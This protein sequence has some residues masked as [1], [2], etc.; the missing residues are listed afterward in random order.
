MTQLRFFDANAMVGRPARPSEE[1]LYEAK[2]LLREMDDL[3]IGNAVVYHAAARDHDPA[4]GNELLVQEVKG[5]PRLRPCYVLLPTATGEMGRLEGIERVL[6]K[7]DV[8][9]VRLFP[10]VHDYRPSPWLLEDLF[11]LLGTLRVP[12]ILEDDTVT[13]DELHSL[14]AS[15]PAVNILFAQRLFPSRYAYRLLEKFA[16]LSVGTWSVGMHRGVED[17]VRRFGPERLVFGTRLPEYAAGGY[18]MRVTHADIPDEAKQMI[19]ERNLLRLM[20]LDGA[21]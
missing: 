19:A 6:K 16:N 4:T 3:G 18:V 14:L 13:Q 10:G 11:G 21:R 8:R 5:L 1:S 12:V 2:D 9:I 17:I 7:H 20:R 15:F